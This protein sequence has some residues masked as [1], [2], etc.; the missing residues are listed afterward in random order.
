MLHRTVAVEF[1]RDVLSRQ[2]RQRENR[3]ESP[4]AAA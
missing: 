1:G 3:T 2:S 4:S